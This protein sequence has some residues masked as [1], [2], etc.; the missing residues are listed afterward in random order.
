VHRGIGAHDVSSLSFNKNSTL[1]GVSSM[2]GLLQ[3][4]QL[5]QARESHKDNEES[6]EENL[7]DYSE[8]NQNEVT[9]KEQSIGLCGLKFLLSKIKSFFVS[10]S[11]EYINAC[12]VTFF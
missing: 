4:Y 8:K 9:S 2:S 3:I 5:K 1:L 10:T 7:S 6:D 12:K 11:L